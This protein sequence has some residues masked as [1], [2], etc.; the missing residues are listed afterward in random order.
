MF[1]LAKGNLSR[2]DFDDS[3]L[4]KAKNSFLWMLNII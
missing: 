4:F 1:L 3:N 2:S